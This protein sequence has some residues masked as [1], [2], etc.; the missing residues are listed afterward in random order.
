MPR[1]R[2]TLSATLAICAL[3]TS[4]SVAAGGAQQEPQPAVQL[5]KLVQEAL[6]RNPEIQAARR[7]IEAKRARIPQARAWPDPRVSFS[8]AGNLPPFTLMRG[9]PSSARRIMAE[10]EIPYRGKTRL[11]GTIA[12]RE[13]DAETLAYELSTFRRRPSHIGAPSSQRERTLTLPSFGSPRFLHFSA[14]PLPV[15]LQRAGSGGSCKE[16]LG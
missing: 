8:Y 11:R 16:K 12:A 1:R 5:A 9:D 13:A 2:K 10:Q 4:S 6:A 7:A 14:A 15:R 3:A